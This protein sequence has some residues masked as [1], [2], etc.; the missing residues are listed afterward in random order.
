M[1]QKSGAKVLERA[2]HE[3][4]ALWRGGNPQSDKAPELERN[5]YENKLEEQR[6]N[7]IQIM[8]QSAK[9]TDDLRVSFPAYQT[10]LERYTP[11]RIFGGAPGRT[12]QVTAREHTA[13][14]Q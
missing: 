7:N 14:Q 1:Q 5:T 9:V 11:S 10:I 6:I 3:Q 4:A 8:A 2:K 13:D 12:R